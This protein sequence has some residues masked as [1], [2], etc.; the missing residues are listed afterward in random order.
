MI[1]SEQEGMTWKA[2]V[3]ETLKGSAGSPRS[4]LVQ[5]GQRQA[6]TTTARHQC[7]NSGRSGFAA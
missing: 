4:G 3:C 5:V 2:A 6:C 7:P 1:R